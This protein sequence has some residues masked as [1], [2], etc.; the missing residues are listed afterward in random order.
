MGVT[1][2]TAKN[3]IS[4]TRWKIEYFDM[5]EKLIKKEEEKEENSLLE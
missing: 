5:Y 2:L 1:A 4:K 3:S